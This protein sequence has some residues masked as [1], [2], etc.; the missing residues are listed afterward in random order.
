MKWTSE[1]PTAPGWYWWR[2]RAG[3][4]P[5]VVEIEESEA[6]PGKLVRRDRDEFLPSY[7]KWAGPLQEPEEDG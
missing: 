4:V 6:F 7:G 1:P 5:S 3:K 2:K